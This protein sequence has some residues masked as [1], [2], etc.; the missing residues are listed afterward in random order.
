MR[1]R[2]S[3]VADEYYRGLEDDVI[4]GNDDV[5]GWRN[6]VESV[7]SM[8]RKEELDWKMVR[9]N[10]DLAMTF[11]QLVVAGLVNWPFSR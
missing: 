9:L 6:G 3:C 2:Y 8:L 10:L 4:P 7:T 11:A 5:K 1:V